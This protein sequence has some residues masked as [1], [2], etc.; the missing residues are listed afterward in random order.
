[1][2]LNLNYFSDIFGR[3]S[4]AGPST[5]ALLTDEAAL[6]PVVSEASFV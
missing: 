1:M 6:L 3:G 5:E 4:G 2:I